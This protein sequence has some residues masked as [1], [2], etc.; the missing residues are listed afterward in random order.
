M[1]GPKVVTVLRPLS[2]VLGFPD[3][4]FSRLTE[5]VRGKNPPAAEMNA[6]ALHLTALNFLLTRAKPVV[7]LFEDLRFRIVTERV[8]EFGALPLTVVMPPATTVRPPDPLIAG[9]IRQSG[10]NAVEEVI[11]VD[12]WNELQDPFLTKFREVVQEFAADSEA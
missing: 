3:F 12:A 4:P 8:P 7:S 11:D 6:F 9:I 2:F 1:D 5:L 10:V